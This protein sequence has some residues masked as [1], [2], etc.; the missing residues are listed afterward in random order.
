MS[1]ERKLGRWHEA[2]LI[3]AETRAR[4]SAFERSEHR[5]IALQA[6]GVL[7]AGAIALGIVSVIASNWDA[8]PGRVKL[9]VDLVLGTALAAAT[10]AAVVGQRGWSAE[11]LI[12]LLYGFTLASLGLVGQVYQLDAPMWRSLLVWSIATLPL[13]L[14]GRS[15]YLATL[16]IAGLVTTQTLSLHALL[17]HLDH[18]IGLRDTTLTNLAVTLIFASSLLWIVVGRVPWLVRNRPEFARTVTAWAWAA[19]VAAGF[20]LQMVWYQ[21]ILPGDTLGWSLAATALLV[22][23]V[24]S[25][26]PRLHPELGARPRASL[27]TLLVAGWLTLA[28]GAGFA[29][30]GISALGAVLQVLWLGL[31]AWAAIGAGYVRVFNLLTGLIALRLLA[32]YFEVF[33]SLLDT[34]LGLIIG[35]VLTLLVGWLWRRKTADLAARLAPTASDDHVA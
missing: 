32:I 10:Y 3:D 7:G 35:G 23:A 13:V 33:G 16:A 19:I 11:V 9:A 20:L 34:G 24:V 2:G 8:I 28:L 4:I 27:A 22:A 21:R 15:R 1:L 17:E 29:R 12:T 18:R 14:L 25:V 30:P 31:C 6:L 5:P 26:L